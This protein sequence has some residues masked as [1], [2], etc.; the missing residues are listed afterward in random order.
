MLLW[1]E[2]IANVAKIKETLLE[3]KSIVQ[4]LSIPSTTTTNVP[5]SWQEDPMSTPPPLPPPLQ[6]SSPVPVHKSSLHVPNSS[7]LLT[8]LN[9]SQNEFS[10][11]FL[12]DT[13]VKSSSRAN[14]AARLV[15]NLYT[16]EECKISNVRGVLGKCK[17]SHTCLD[18]IKEATIQMYPCDSGENL[19][20]VWTNCCKA[21]DG[22][23]CRLNRKP[24]ENIPPTSEHYSSYN[25]TFNQVIIE[26]LF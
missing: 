11:S 24:K 3:V 4:S 8:P 10:T 20:Q 5:N 1:S 6:Q 15:R 16:E 13:K 22:T 25:R 21:I 19:A 7:T 26:F 23:C 14:F 9:S 12:V 18:R 17:L 2:L